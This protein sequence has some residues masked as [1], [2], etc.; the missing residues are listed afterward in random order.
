MKSLNLRCV[1]RLAAV[2]GLGIVLVGCDSARDI[3]GLSKTSPDESRVTVF[4]PLVVPPDFSLRPPGPG[5]VDRAGV[6]QVP[7][8]PRS[9]AV[10]TADG[11]VVGGIT[12]EESIPE[13][14]SPGELALLRQAGA[15][16]PPKGVRGLAA[17]QET[18]VTRL[19]SLLTEL[20]LFNNSPGKQREPSPQEKTLIK[21]QGLFF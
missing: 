18:A 1:S 14:A 2:A 4:S 3:L 11:R 8:R 13:D 21:R 9:G 10:I 6:P 19:N 5:G 17:Q 15:L 20:I 16:T 7:R 12:G